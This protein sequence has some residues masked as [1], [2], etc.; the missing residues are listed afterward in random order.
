NGNG[1]NGKRTPFA[2]DSSERLLAIIDNH[3]VQDLMITVEAVAAADPVQVLI[4]LSAVVRTLHVLQRQLPGLAIGSR[5]FFG[6]YDFDWE[7]TILDMLASKLDK[8]F[9]ENSCSPDFIGINSAQSLRTRLMQGSK[10]IWFGV[11]CIIRHKNRRK[12]IIRICHP[13]RKD[14]SSPFL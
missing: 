9:I 6:M 8:L 3:Q 2:G 4:D 13:S 11:D 7:D 10:E 5:F 1:Q 12:A 14:E